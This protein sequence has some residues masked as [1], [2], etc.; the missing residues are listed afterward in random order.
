MLAVL[1]KEIWEN[2]ASLRA[3]LLYFSS[4]I[5]LAFSTENHLMYRLFLNIFTAVRVYETEIISVLIPA[6]RLTRIEKLYFIQYPKCL[7]L[8][9]LQYVSLVQLGLQLFHSTLHLWA[10]TRFL[11]SLKLHWSVFLPVQHK[12]FYA[13]APWKKLL[14]KNQDSERSMALH[15]P[16]A[17]QYQELNVPELLHSPTAKIVT[18]DQVLLLPEHGNGSWGNDCSMNACVKCTLVDFKVERTQ[19]P[20]NV[21]QLEAQSFVSEREELLSARKN[22]AGKGA[23][24]VDIRSLSEVL[25]LKFPLPYLILW[26]IPEEWEK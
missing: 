16:S 20:N 6:F 3:T 5:I 1:S 25:C 13:P 10:F 7:S 15:L 26:P 23:T 19:V 12:P 21:N 18:K 11:Q 17:R 22:D 24:T 9:D 14:T 4:N 8:L 2:P